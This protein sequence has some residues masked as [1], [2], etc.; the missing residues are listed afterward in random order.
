MKGVKEAHKLLLAVLA[1][2]GIDKAMETLKKAPLG[3]RGSK[4]TKDE[5]DTLLA[6]AAESMKKS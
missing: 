2:Q 6:M 4:L 5:I 1:H 3:L